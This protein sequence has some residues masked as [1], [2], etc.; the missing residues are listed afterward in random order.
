MPARRSRAACPT[1]PSCR[2]RHESGKAAGLQRS[3]RLDDEIVVEPEPVATIEGIGADHAVGK[4]RIADRQIELRRQRYTREIR[5]VDPGARLQETGDPR[6]DGID[7][8]AATASIA[9]GIS[10]GNRPVTMAGSRMRPTLETQT[11]QTGPDGTDDELRRE[12]GILRAAGKRRLVGPGDGRLE[13]IA[14][15]VP[16]PREALLAGATE[17]AVWRVRKNRSR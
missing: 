1:C 14:K 17:D 12:M 11:K 7:L 8:D 4:G 3:D 9:S 16:S 15:L 6:G 5:I 13:V 2:L 10:A